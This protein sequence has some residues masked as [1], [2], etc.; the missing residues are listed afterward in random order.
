MK[1]TGNLKTVVQMWA[2]RTVPLKTPKG[3]SLNL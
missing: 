3:K 2:D 1:N